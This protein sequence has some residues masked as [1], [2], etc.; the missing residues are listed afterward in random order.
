MD[1]CRDGRLPYRTAGAP[2]SSGTDRMVP[3]ATV[4]AL[5]DGR[6]SE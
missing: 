3:L 6:I 1:R 5:V 4:R 2:E